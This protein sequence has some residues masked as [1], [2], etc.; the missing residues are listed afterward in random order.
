MSMYDRDF[1][2]LKLGRERRDEGMERVTTGNPEFKV[3]FAQYL[4]RLPHGWVGQCEDIRK[5]WTG[6]YAKPQ[7]W[8][9]CWNAAKKR[10]VIVELEERAPMTGVKSNARRTNL[11]RRV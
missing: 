11:Y 9:A 5:V 10:G 2:D 4:D 7:A 3:Q 6:I 8:G 1:F